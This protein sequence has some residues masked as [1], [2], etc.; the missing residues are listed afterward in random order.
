MIE[1]LIRGLL[2]N[3]SLVMLALSLV[4]AALRSRRD[5][6]RFCGSLLR[7][8]LLLAVGVTGIYT[9]VM[10]VFFPAASAENIGWA[11]SP[12]Q[13]E[14]GVADLTVGV[15]GV[16]AFWGNFGFRLATVVATTIWLW[17]DALGHVRQLIVAHNFAPGNA[18]PWFWTD[19]L[20]PLVLLACTFL[21]WRRERSN[22]AGVN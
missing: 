22:S 6:E 16:L 7:W 17:G 15:L 14:V 21:V 3:F 9:F 5:G 20:L 2:D 13:Y 18:G 4:F 19:I 12:F 8:L 11:V 10:H 1:T